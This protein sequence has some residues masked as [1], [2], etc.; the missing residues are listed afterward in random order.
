MT[1]MDSA[2]PPGVSQ[3]LWDV[4]ACPCPAH[5]TLAF[6]GPTGDI[7]AACCGR[8]FTVRDGIP[9]MLLDDATTTS[10]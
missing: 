7:V 1:S 5:G 2:P 4:L 8:H 9:V 10:A 6:D 3:E